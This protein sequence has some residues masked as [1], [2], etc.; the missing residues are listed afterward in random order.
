MDENKTINSLVVEIIHLAVLFAFV[1]SFLPSFFPRV[2][3][4]FVLQPND[5][6]VAGLFDD[7]LVRH[8]VRYLGGGY[9]FLS[10]TSMLCSR[11][12]RGDQKAHI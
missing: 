2:M 8:Q 6:K 12:F 10:D 3:F 11:T 9:I 7:K 1:F 4:F 5:R